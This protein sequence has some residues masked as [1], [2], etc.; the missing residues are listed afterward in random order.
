[1]LPPSSTQDI[2]PSPTS[3]GAV[4]VARPIIRDLVAGALGVLGA[5]LLMW[6]WLEAHH[7]VPLL[8]LVTYLVMMGLV[9]LRLPR[10][11]PQL[12]WANRV[13]LWRGALVAL[14]AGTLAHPELLARYT[15]PL[16][17][18]ALLALALDGVDGWIA[19]RT[20]TQSEFG[21]HFDMELDAFL[22]LVLCLAL[23]SLDKAGP[24]VLTIGTMRYAFV[25]AGLK[26]R[27]LT[28]PLPESRR[29]KLICVWQVAA[30]M[31]ALLPAV[32]TTATS[33]LAG[34]ALV[35]LA[36]S[37]LVDIGWLYRHAAA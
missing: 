32:G 11:W 22:I 12:G 24:W 25:I 20:S 13:T 5:S 1:M 34:S 19:R 18:L 15:V 35:G 28:A 33:W 36:W 26:F 6:S 10:G 3:Q 16:A 31:I 7:A 17:T 21:A 4:G 8:A 2:N 37:F 14:L 9:L 27:W 23:L 29:R 30:L